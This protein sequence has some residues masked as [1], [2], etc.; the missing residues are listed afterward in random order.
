MP[1]RDGILECWNTGFG[2]IRSVFDSTEQKIKSD[3]HPHLIPIFLFSITPVF[4]GFSD[5]K[6]HCSLMKSKPGP[7]G[8]DSLLLCDFLSITIRLDNTLLEFGK[9]ELKLRTKRQFYLKE[10]TENGC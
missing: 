6:D 5:C 4:H 7:L 3:H 8:Q 2:G 10:L 1:W 9:M